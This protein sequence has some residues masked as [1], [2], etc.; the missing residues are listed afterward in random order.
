MKINTVIAVMVVLMLYSL[1]APLIF[2][3]RRIGKI[4]CPVVQAATVITKQ[5]GGGEDSSRTVKASCDYYTLIGRPK[6]SRAIELDRH[7]SDLAN[8]HPEATVGDTFVCRSIWIHYSPMALEVESDKHVR[9]D[10]ESCHLV[11]LK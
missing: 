11:K 1:F 7:I 2:S 10:L 4:T 8:K 9:F 6:R 3:E 5:D